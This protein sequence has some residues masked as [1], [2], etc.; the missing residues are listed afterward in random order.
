MTSA[1]EL[2]RAY[3]QAHLVDRDALH[4]AQ[5]K[6]DALM[7]L[8]TLKQ[9]FTT[10]VA[11][12]PGRGAP[13]RGR[14]DRSRS[15]TFRAS[16]YRA[17]KAEERPARAGVAAADG[18]SCDADAAAF[19]AVDLGAGSGRAILGRRRGAGELLLEEVR[20]FQYSAARQRRPPALGRR[21]GSSDEV[22][23]RL[24]RGRARGH[25][26][27]GR[28]VRASAS[29]AGASTTAWSTRRA[30]GRGPRLLSRRAHRRRV[31]ARVFARVPRAE[32]F[33]RTGI[34]FLQF[35]TLFQLDAH[36]RDGLPPSARAAAADPG[37]RATIGSPGAPPPSTRTPRR[38]SSST[39]TTGEWDTRPRGAPR[40][41]RRSCSVRSCPR[42]PTSG[43]ST[44][45]RAAELGLEGVR[46]VA[47]ATHDT[48][49]AVAGAPLA[50]RLG[51]RLLRHLVARRRRAH[52][53]AREP[54]TWPARTSRT[55]AAPTAR[56]A[57]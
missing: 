41:A 3:V 28:P 55:K 31:R 26:R 5:E 14:R 43:R 30:A 47:P 53:A 36:H 21:R 6:C 13:A 1:V 57:S 50:P 8:G 19:L 18:Q 45:A 4:D 52:G 24:A 54:P 40:P 42:G 29:T 46:V 39:P 56:S 49:S 17:R 16:G 48:G 33:R 2:V 9:A 22:R 38:R 37:P 7:A 51:L 23:G 12:D 27:R 11:P 25:A 15:A 20:R 35:N 32:I 44:R 10:D 34:Q